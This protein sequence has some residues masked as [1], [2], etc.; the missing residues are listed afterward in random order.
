MLYIIHVLLLWGIRLSGNFEGKVRDFDVDVVLISYCFLTILIISVW[1]LT[2]TEVVGNNI[3]TLLMLQS[4]SFI[5]TDFTKEVSS[6]QMIF[7][8]ASRTCL[9]IVPLVLMKH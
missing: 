7:S 1:Y 3:T 4:F 8:S 2:Q 5:K 6:Y 9:T